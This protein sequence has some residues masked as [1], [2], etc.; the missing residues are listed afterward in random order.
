MSNPNTNPGQVKEN[1]SKS[2][3]LPPSQLKTDS[4]T[5]EQSKSESSNADGNKSGMGKGEFKADSNKGNTDKNTQ[6]TASQI[7]P[8]MPVVCSKNGQF[9]I[10]DHMQGADSIKLKKDANGKHHFIP[11][12]WVASVDTSLHLNRPGEEAMRDWRTES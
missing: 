10:V 3:Q 2:G 1:E 5:N 11:L 8:E 4:K 12:S 9:G 7:K 6:V